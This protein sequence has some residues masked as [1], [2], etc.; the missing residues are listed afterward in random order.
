MYSSYDYSH[1][2]NGWWKEEESYDKDVR[3]PFDVHTKVVTKNRILQCLNN[4]KC[5]IDNKESHNEKDNTLNNALRI[6]LLQHKIFLTNICRVK[7]CNLT[8]KIKLIMNFS[9]F[10]IY[11]NLLS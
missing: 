4:T 9:I 6:I 1:D 10:Y 5:T 7:F 2:T 3:C 11:R 8:V